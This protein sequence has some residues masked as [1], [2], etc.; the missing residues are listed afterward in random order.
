M[1]HCSIHAPCEVACPSSIA[2]QSS[3]LAEFDVLVLRA[4]ATHLA[5]DETTHAEEQRQPYQ[6]RTCT[7][8]LSQRCDVIDVQNAVYTAV[9]Q[10]VM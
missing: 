8:H 3:A 9:Q 7:L 5:S 6:N 2:F 4:C 10:L 1:Q